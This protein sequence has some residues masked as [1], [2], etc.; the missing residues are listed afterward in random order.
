MLHDVFERAFLLGRFMRSAVFGGRVRCRVI[1]SLRGGAVF[2]AGVFDSQNL[3]FWS[4]AEQRYVMYFRTFKAIRDKRYRWISRTTSADFLNWSEP[5]DMTFGDA[6]PE[7]LY[8]NQ[9]HPYFRAPHIYIALAK[10]FF[11]AKAALTAAQAK[12]LV[13]N[14][15][16]RVASSDS[17]F[18]TTR[19]GGHYDRTFMEAFIRP[20]PSLEDWVARDNTPALGVV[21]ANERE[22]FIYRMSHYA[23]PTSHMARYALRTDGFS[24]V[25]APYRGGELFTKPFT[26]SGGKLEINFATSAAG[27]VRVEIQ[28]ENGKAMP[29]FALADCPE[30]IGDEIDRV[31]SWKGG[32]EVGKFAGKVVRLRFAMKDADLYSLRFF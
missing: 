32:M 26:F 7:H 10:R 21:P 13:D 17:I 5:V 18:M 6:P 15:G 12:A 23:Q 4:D 27:G 16:Y 11:P 8:I 28:D 24:S 1:R 2:R 22:M 29:G 30:M 20:G 25:N 14:P 19:G 9:T 31:I 3:A